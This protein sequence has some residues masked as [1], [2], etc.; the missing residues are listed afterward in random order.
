MFVVNQ[1]CGIATDKFNGNF[2]IIGIVI[3]FTLLGHNI[4]GRQAEMIL[5]YPQFKLVGHIDGV[6]I[7][8]NRQYLL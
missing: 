3:S 1:I 6:A 4:G 5:E 8:D 2:F 7:K